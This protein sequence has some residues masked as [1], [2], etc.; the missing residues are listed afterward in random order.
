MAKKL[1]FNDFLSV[2]YMPG[3]PDLVKKNAKKRK[4]DTATGSNA[5]YSSTHAPQKEEKTECPKCNGKGCDHCDNTGYHMNES[6]NV[7][8]R[9]ARSRSMKKYKSRL[10]IGR[11]RAAAKL[12]TSDTLKR[13]ARKAAR[14]AIAKKIT[15]GIAKS[16]LTFARKQEIEKRLE[17]MTGRIN[18]LA[19]KMVPKIRKAEMERKRSKK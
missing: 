8:Q 6:L 13:R 15:K 3:E 2:D 9:R 5:E 1:G 18:K 14:N 7:Q 11:K 10:A 17:K 16:D 19:T 4:Q 12:A